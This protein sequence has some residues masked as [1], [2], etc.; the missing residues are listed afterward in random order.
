MP[1]FSVVNLNPKQL[2]Q[3][4]VGSQLDG[5]PACINDADGVCTM[6]PVDDTHG[7]VRS[8]SSFSTV[9]QLYL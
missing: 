3:G 8:L 7:P 2:F 4:F 1:L 5:L 6:Q 9:T